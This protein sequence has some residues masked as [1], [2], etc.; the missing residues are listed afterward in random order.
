MSYSVCCGWR[1][2]VSHN[3]KQTRTIIQ[4][5]CTCI[6]ADV[7]LYLVSTCYM[8][9]CGPAW[10]PH[11]CRWC[12]LAPDIE[13]RYNQIPLLAYNHPPFP[14]L[15]KKPP[16]AL[17]HIHSG[18]SQQGPGTCAPIPARNK[19]IP[20]FPTCLDVWF[21]GNY[22]SEGW[23]WCTKENW[24]WCS[25]MSAKQYIAQMWSTTTLPWSRFWTA[26]NKQIA[27]WY[28]T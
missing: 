26:C 19:C 14:I 27:L 24:I 17:V 15:W 6:H 10:E 4:Q 23:I 5:L 28:A 18:V 11:S 12:A 25:P 7:T 22:H 21:G 1:N 9:R 16:H 20:E 13:D 8:Y 2:K 3:E